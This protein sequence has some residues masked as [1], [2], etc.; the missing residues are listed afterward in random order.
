MKQRL[1]AFLLSILVAGKAFACPEPSR[2]LLFHSCWGAA[3]MELRLLP[4]SL[5][6][7]PANATG[8]RLIV[9]GAYTGTEPRGAGLP[10]P[11]GLFV[12]RGAVVNPNLGR[13]DGVLLIDPANGQPQ[14]NHRTRLPLGGRIYDLTELDQRLAFIDAASK[15]GLSVLQSHLLIVDGQIDVRPQEDA[16][17]FV[18]RMLFTDPSGFGVYQ[19]R[20]PETLHDAVRRLAGA[21]APRMALNLDMGSYDYCQGA[22]GGMESSCGGLSRDNTGKLSNLLVLTLE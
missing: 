16:P 20:W 4:E 1:A 12:D 8:R 15:R 9:T 3:R 6:L 11:V 14:L 22:T 17:V 5:P 21:V 18:R 10:K 19:T 13:M 7:P 2:E